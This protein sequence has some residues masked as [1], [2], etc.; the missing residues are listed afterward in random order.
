M[1]ERDDGEQRPLTMTPN[2]SL[3]A[4]CLAA[5]LIL[6]APVTPAQTATPEVDPETQGA[7]RLFS[8]WLEGRIAYRDL[9]G[10]VVGVVRGDDLVWAEGFGW[11]DLDAETPMATDTRFRMASHSKLFTA[12]AIM[13]LREQGL[14]RLDDPV[15]EHLPWF[16][17]EPASPDDP[18]ITIEHILTHAS[19]LPREADQ[20]WSTR[21]FPDREQ[22]RARVLEKT[23]VY[24]PE[25]R[26]KYSNLAYSL[27]GLIVEE[28]S[29]QTWAD[30]LESEVFDPLGMTD[31]SVDVDDPLLAR[32][33]GL[34]LPD[35]SR[36]RMEFVNAA[37]MASATGLTSTV[38][39]MARFVSAQFRKG[40]RGDNRILG[41]ASLRE[42]HR[43]RMLESDWQSGQ[44]IG[45]SVR[46]VEDRVFIGHGGGYP[47]YTTYTLIDPEARIGVIALTNANDSGAREIAGELMASVGH[48]VAEAAA[49]NGGE[50]DDSVEWDPAWS[51]FAGVYRGLGDNHVVLLHEKLV[52]LQ[53]DTPRIGEPVEL[54]PLGD[55]RF[56][57][58]APTGGGPVGEVVRFEE[59]DGRVL[60]MLLGDYIYERIE[61][62]G[63]P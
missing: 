22:L 53:P 50:V 9:P 30:Y 34:R 26:W 60:R 5:M 61:G 29:G 17:V 21:V 33:Y 11:A 40:A 63:I 46:R 37:G 44:G 7:I 41:T 62:Y 13:Q 38:P 12:T 28:L 56:R 48:A 15:R 36:E 57:F 18:L 54:E 58:N 51:R 24:S 10:V 27:A 14:V 16:E 3:R 20:H 8:A 47:G 45:F 25:E 43:V 55:G 2:R 39:D 52:L 23:A 6:L 31:S 32:G 42:M 4:G 35:G 59:A 49:K 1:Q 19:G